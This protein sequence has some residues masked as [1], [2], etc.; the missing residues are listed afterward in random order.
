MQLK[1]KIYSMFLVIFL[2]IGGVAL[3]S[4]YSSSDSEKKK[5]LD[6]L[7]FS[8]SGLE[9]FTLVERFQP[10][11]SEYEGNEERIT[12]RDSGSS[13]IKITS[14]QNAER[15]L[16]EDYTSSQSALLEGMFDTKIPPYPE[17]LTNATGCDEELL[18]KKKQTNLGMYYT[19]YADER[20]NQGICARDITRY[21]VG[22][23]IFYC[24]Q[25][26]RIVKVMYYR[27]KGE[28]FSQIVNSLE[29]FSCSKE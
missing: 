14:I 22:M 6:D 18:P 28:D 29:S 4:V 20:L 2:I 27:D 11:F 26:K 9:N 1:K 25:T 19:T 7:G 15:S 13:V 12:L 10:H 23:G 16:A 17:L 8:M 24:E 21:K 3:F 5:S